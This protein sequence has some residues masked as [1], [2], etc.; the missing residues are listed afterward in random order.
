MM[1]VFLIT[2]LLTTSALA[3]VNSSVPE[4]ENSALLMEGQKEIVSLS[5]M[6][7]LNL[8]RGET[9]ID[10]WSGSYWPV[11]QGSVGLRYRD[12]NF[13]PLIEGQFQ[14]DAHK[15]LREALPLYTYSGK[16]N[17]LSPAEKYDLLVGDSEM[18]LTK[19]AWELGQKNNLIGK[20]KTWRGICDGWASASQK[21]P[22]PIRSVTLKTLS[23]I[24]ITFYPEDIKAL[25]S[26]MYARSQKPVIFIGKRCRNQVLGLFS[27]ACSETNPGTFHRAIVNRIG[28]MKKSF[29]A[30]IS[31]G[32]EVWNYPV[33]GYRFV[34]Y[35]V[36]DFSESKNF[37][38]VKELFIKKNR[39]SK[40]GKR[41]PNTHS[42]VGVKI[43]VT[44][45]DM[46]KANLFETDG[47]SMD[48]SFEKEFVYD[49]ELDKDNNILG[50]ESFSKNL[51]DFIWA[52]NDKTYPLSDA[53]EMT[54]ELAI[55]EQSRA[56]AR[57]GQPLAKIVKTLF[58]LAK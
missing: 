27:G 5:E 16:E 45:K 38:D 50:G 12:P 34:Y 47:P 15:R 32:G 37:E 26:L 18:S 48:Q 23:G 20:V 52:P 43:L 24:P 46:R 33:Q 39:F 56:S 54:P 53:E 40:S 36:F 51:P 10:L 13:L 8:L 55:L 1:K 49:L 2:T 7:K 25:G 58:E 31:P 21:M 6:A 28:M 57:K 41:H 29:I 9:N 19:Y 14:W 22:R 4:N 44:F 17:L 35:N 30:D 11:Y 42:I 3:G